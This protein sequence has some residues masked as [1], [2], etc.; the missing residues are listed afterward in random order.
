[1]IISDRY[2][3][4]LSGKVIP[5]SL[6]RV[7]NFT[8][9]FDEYT[10]KKGD[11]LTKI[12]EKELA[13]YGVT[14]DK[15]RLPQIIKEI[16]K[17]NHLKNPNLIY[18]GQKLKININLGNNLKFDFPVDG[19]ITSRYG[20]RLDPYTK[21][22]KF[23]KGIDIAAPVGTPVKSVMDGKVIFTGWIR[24]YG[25]IVI[26]KN[27]NLITKYAHN[28]KILVKKGDF[29]KKGE[30]IAEVGKTGRATGPH[31]HF[32]VVLNGRNV[33]PINYFNDNEVKYHL[34]KR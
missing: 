27:G 12:I 13:K 2:F 20:P 34:A 8:K 23:H 16:A 15:K 28:S 14:L 26:I 4:S 25:E 24:G 11:N 5:E 6:N 21:T 33:D 9:I 3:V 17:E 30:I 31:L 10:V 19:I 18:A 1:M 7:K 22:I 32:E 29:V